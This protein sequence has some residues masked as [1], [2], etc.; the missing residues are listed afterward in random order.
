MQSTFLMTWLPIMLGL[1]LLAVWAAGVAD[2]ART[3]ERD[4]RT[5]PQA[6][7]LCILLL[8]SFMG[9]LMW[10]AAGRPRRS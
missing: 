1:V 5:L 8:G 10:F 4:I 2:F 9:A 7:W 3:D 6:A